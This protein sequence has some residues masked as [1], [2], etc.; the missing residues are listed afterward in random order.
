MEKFYLCSNK[1]TKRQGSGWKISPKRDSFLFVKGN[2]FHT[3]HQDTIWPPA[4]Q[5]PT[6]VPVLPAHLLIFLSFPAPACCAEGAG[7]AWDLF[8][9][10]G[11]NETQ[12]PEEEHSEPKERKKSSLCRVCLCGPLAAPEP[13]KRHAIQLRVFFLLQK[14]HLSSCFPRCTARSCT[15]H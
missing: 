6:S 5:K 1:G 7:L 11:A 15:R 8:S 12:S 3:P 4:S 9:S 14:Q 13:S 10:C 2:H